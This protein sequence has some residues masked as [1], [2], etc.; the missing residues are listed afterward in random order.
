[1]HEAILAAAVVGVALITGVIVGLVV[2][3]VFMRSLGEDDGYPR[4]RAARTP[5][6]RSPFAPER[7]E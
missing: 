5:A 1:M 4:L 3:L 2:Y 6:R 7:T